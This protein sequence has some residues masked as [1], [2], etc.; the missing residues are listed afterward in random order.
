MDCPSACTQLGGHSSPS[1][2]CC[3]SLPGASACSQQPPLSVPPA[4]PSSRCQ[5]S[6]V[7]TAGTTY[8]RA[9][10]RSPL[11]RC[12]PP[13]SPLLK[14]LFVGISIT[15]RCATGVC[16][17]VSVTVKTSTCLEAPQKSAW[18]PPYHIL[19]MD[20]S[21]SI[22]SVRLLVQQLRVYTSHTKDHDRSTTCLQ[23]KVYRV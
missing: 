4:L 2:C 13:T 11:L 15:Y 23:L 10:A 22:P 9:H 21:T 1:L 16:A 3:S 7:A 6:A 5:R 20:Q 17:M 8:C 14:A 19:I 12:P 18:V